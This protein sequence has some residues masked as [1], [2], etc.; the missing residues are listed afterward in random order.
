[1]A[2]EG[3]LVTIVVLYYGQPVFDEGM[4]CS[5]CYAGLYKTREK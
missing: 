5:G 2:G 1:M 3:G 4:D